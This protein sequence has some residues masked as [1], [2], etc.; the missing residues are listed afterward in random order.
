[1]S[2]SEC[3]ESYNNLQKLYASTEINERCVDIDF[4]FAFICAMASSELELEQWMPLLFVNGESSFSSERMASDFAQTVLA[5]YQQ[6]NQTFEQGL[7][8]Q[9]MIQNSISAE[10]DA[11]FNFANGYLQ[12]LTLIDNM[13]SSHFE[14]G[15]AEANLQQTCFLLLDKLATLETDD[16]Q[17]MAV[18]TQLPTN[19]EIVALLPELLTHYGQLCLAVQK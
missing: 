17:K 6:V 13:Q 4:G 10:Q 16:A 1:M 14:E 7:P 12:A 15:S 5:I 8:L 2:N 9:L 18:F 11:T 3:L 19:S